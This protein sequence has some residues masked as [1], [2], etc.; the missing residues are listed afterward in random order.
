MEA[1]DK[2]DDVKARIQDQERIPPDWQCLLCA[3]KKI[4]AKTRADSTITL[5]VKM[6]DV[7][8]SVKAQAR[9]KDDIKPGKG[10][11][12]HFARRLRGGMQNSVTTFTGETTGLDV[13]VFDTID[14]GKEGIQDKKRTML[15]CLNGWTV[16]NKG[17]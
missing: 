7:T 8:D 4:F 12:L 14:T 13:E 16:C 1:P 5:D 11:A 2:I 15:I 9:D 10:P 3:G 6:S 17:F